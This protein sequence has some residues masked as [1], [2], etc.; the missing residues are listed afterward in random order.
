MSG[1][2]NVYILVHQVQSSPRRVPTVVLLE[3]M[4]PTNLV[5]FQCQYHGFVSYQF[6]SSSRLLYIQ[7]R[8]FL[9]LPVTFAMRG[10][11]GCYSVRVFFACLRR[12]RRIVRADPRLEN[13]VARPAGLMVEASLDR[14]DQL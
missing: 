11:R 9:H 12:H 6:L 4:S 1:D 13:L 5:Q 14:G 3:G 10:L 2:F 8:P 7:Q